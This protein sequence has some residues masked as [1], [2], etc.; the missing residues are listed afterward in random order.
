MS[1]SQFA[2]AAVYRTLFGI[3][4]CYLTARLA[5]QRPLFHA[6]ILGAIGTVIS[7]LGVVAALSQGGDLGPLWY[8]VSL[9]LT[10][11]PSAW[12]GARLHERASQPLI[13]AAA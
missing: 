3:F 6:L 8:A 9:V 1:A 11:L 10:A 4:G 7:M 13:R 12:L 2:L 5:P